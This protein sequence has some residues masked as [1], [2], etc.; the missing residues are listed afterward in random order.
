MNNGFKGGIL[1]EVTDEDA[2][3]FGDEIAVRLERK[4]LHGQMYG[5]II[6]Q[7]LQIFGNTACEHM[8]L[9]NFIETLAWKHLL[10]FRQLKR[11]NIQ[12]SFDAPAMFESMAETPEV[13]PGNPRTLASDIF[14]ATLLLEAL[15]LSNDLMASAEFFMRRLAIPSSRL[16]SSADFRLPLAMPFWMA[17][18]A[19][20]FW[21]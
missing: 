2:L 12:F 17:A 6:A 13:R 5:R 10:S 16:A 1:A 19:L 4:I 8:R 18:A 3:I 7:K 9:Q 20:S 21:P 11:R 15:T 14:L